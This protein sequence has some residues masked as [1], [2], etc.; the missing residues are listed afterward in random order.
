MLAETLHFILSK[1]H[2]RREGPE[3]S[4]SSLWLCVGSRLWGQGGSMGPGDTMV[5]RVR[6]METGK[7]RKGQ[8]WDCSAVGAPRIA[9]S[10]AFPSQETL[11]PL[12]QLLKSRA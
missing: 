11:A 12:A 1:W 8:I 5:T 9:P 10:H 6:V 4:V 7:W 2:R 3:V